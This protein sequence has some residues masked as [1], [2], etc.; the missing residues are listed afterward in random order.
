M[1]GATTAAQLQDG[2]LHSQQ[3]PGRPQ[4][5]PPPR[6]SKGCVFPDPQSNSSQLLVAVSSPRLRRATSERVPK[7]QTQGSRPYNPQG[8]NMNSGRT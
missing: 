6:V 1:D 7:R 2:A 4:T 3:N 8:A 5:Q